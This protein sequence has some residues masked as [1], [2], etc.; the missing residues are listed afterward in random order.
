MHEIARVFTKKL[1]RKEE[2]FLM[3]YLT[4][5]TFRKVGIHTRIGAY[6]LLGVLLFNLWKIRLSIGYFQAN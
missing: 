4:I 3:N 2:I 5:S 6:S 1:C